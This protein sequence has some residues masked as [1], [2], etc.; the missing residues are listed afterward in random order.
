MYV[1]SQ[2]PGDVNPVLP[3]LA[4]KPI[5]A[6]LARVRMSLVLKPEQQREYLRLS[7]LLQQIRIHYR[8]ELP[9]GTTSVLLTNRDHKVRIEAYDK[10]GKSLGI[11]PKDKTSSAFQRELATSF[12]NETSPDPDGI[13][14]LI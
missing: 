8:R 11:I 6:R 7:G 5:K 13:L 9:E 4:R 1:H 12:A 2:A 10:A 3:S 14:A